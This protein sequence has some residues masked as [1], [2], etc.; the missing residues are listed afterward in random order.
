MNNSA[1]SEA[2]LSFYIES[3]NQYHYSENT[4][5]KHFCIHLDSRIIAKNHSVD[6]KA[7]WTLSAF[8]SIYD[9]DK[10]KAAKFSLSLAHEFPQTPSPD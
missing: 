2:M 6:F 7:T 8:I 9:Y 4:V 5:T 3:K 10:A 1:V